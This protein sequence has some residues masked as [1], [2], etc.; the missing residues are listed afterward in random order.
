MTNFEF[1]RNIA[2][3]ALFANAAIEA[4][5]VFATSPAM[6]AVGCRKALELA[7]K[8]V[9]SADT[10]ISMPYNDNLQSLIHEPSFRFALD[11]QTWGK[12]LFIIRLGNLSVH[13]ERA[14]NKA[15]ALLA[16]ESLF[17][18]IEW[19]DYCYGADYVE[20]HFDS[21]LI[22]AEKVVLDTKKIKEQQSLI[23]QKDSEIK[24][25][26]AKIA[27][28][29]AMLT[30]GKEEKRD[31]R[32]FTPADLSEVETRKIYIDVALKFM[33]WKFHSMILL[34]HKNIRLNPHTLNFWKTALPA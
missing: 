21:A 10:T 2:D 1:L 17:E 25:L 14:V 8:W 20:R 33:G 34:L 9:Y 22:P 15:D 7:V 23:E 32:S 5:K 29:S 26:Q 31:S 4:E 11:S 12:L 16:L 28:M 6:C 30:A 27:E 18:F 19:I 13:T 24:A 3:Y